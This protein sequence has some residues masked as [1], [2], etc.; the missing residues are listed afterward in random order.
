MTVLAIDT[1]EGTCSAAILAA[2]GTFAGFFSDTIN[3]G[4]AEYC[5]PRLDEMMTSSGMAYQ[6]LTRIAVTTGPG[7]F[8]GVRV[9]LSVARGLGAALCVPVLGLSALEVL[10]A[11]TEGLSINP[12]HVVMA[13]RGG[14]AFYQAFQGLTDQGRPKPISDPGHFDHAEIKNK[15]LALPAPVTG[16]GAPDFDARAPSC[17]ID[18]KVLARLGQDSP[19]QDAPAR[20][21]YLKA[22]DAATAKPVFPLGPVGQE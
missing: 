21:L 3:R 16:S 20:P 18:P 8:T 5:L 9:G 7:N 15:L 10:A 13:G 22:P 12:V 19:A 4:H 14:Q 1:C 6:D 2:D 17:S 11:Q